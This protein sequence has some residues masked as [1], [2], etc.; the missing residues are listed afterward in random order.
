[1]MSR[2]LDSKTERFL[3]AT[4][5][6]SSRSEYPDGYGAEV[7]LIELAERTN[8]ASTPPTTT[9]ASAL[10]SIATR[11]DWRFQLKAKHPHFFCKHPL[12]SKF[13]CKFQCGPGWCDIIE[14]ACVRI[15][16]VLAGRE[17]FRFE[18]IRERNGE[19]RM[20]WGGWLTARSEAAVRYAID[21]AQARSRCICEVCGDTGRLRRDGDVRKTCCDLHAQGEAVPVS[22]E[23]KNL[24]LAQKWTIGR[25]WTMVIRRYDPKS[26]DFTELDP[27]D[28]EKY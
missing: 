18:E 25:Q 10:A 9:N 22:T 6:H 3:R 7:S 15:A 23:F 13:G 1:M 26:D 27:A 19:L 11:S 12:D 5:V 14:R 17:Q 8:R 28:A 16:A 21:L 2:S 24:H 20:Y 4:A